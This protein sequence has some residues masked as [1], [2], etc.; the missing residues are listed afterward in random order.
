VNKISAEKL[1]NLSEEAYARLRDM[2]RDGELPAGSRVS[3][4][5]LSRKLGISRTPVRD[6]IRRLAGEGLVK[7]VPG[8]GAFVRMPTR[9]ELV[10]LYDMR[11]LLESYAATEA[12]AKMTADQLEELA[13][14]CRQWRQLTEQLRRLHGPGLLDR[15]YQR[16]IAIDDRFHQ[17][18]VG[19]AR[20][21]LLSKTIG[22]M[23]LLSRTLHL[24]Q[25]D[26]EPQISFRSAAWSYRQHATL[27]R[28]LRRRDAAT[29]CFW[30]KKQI[31][32]GKQRH[33]A[34]LDAAGFESSDAEKGI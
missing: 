29:A 25:F 34:H 7:Q 9:A 2:L 32:V 13:D 16:W 11:E 1:P 5:E 18:L 30:M 27:V 4:L 15:L 22:D 26:R 14:C 17:V 20:N 8:N 10:E 19:S 24:R 31:R 3:G 6:A 21:G 28:A 23:R 12:A 33:L